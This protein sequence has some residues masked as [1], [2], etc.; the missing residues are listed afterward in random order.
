MAEQVNSLDDILKYL[1]A[2]LSSEEL[3]LE[4]SAREFADKSQEEINRVAQDP[5]FQ[6]K[7]REFSIGR[8]FGSGNLSKGEGAK[9]WDVMNQFIHQKILL[10][11]NPSLDA[12]CKINAIVSQKEGGI[13]R[14]C[15]SFAGDKEFIKPSDLPFFLRAFEESFLKK[16]GANP[17]FEAFMIYTWGTTLHP[18]K[19]GNGRTFR[20]C[21]DWILLGGGLLPVSFSSSV[22]AHVAVSQNTLLPKRSQKFS[23]FLAAHKA[24]YLKL[25]P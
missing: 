11:E 18:F 1:S 8:M 9:E 17:L 2:P 21:S 7:W 25:T 5:S 19:D 13:I 10:G 16:L 24:S 20:G 23:Q 12:I 22:S 14:D 15:Y 3:S 6:N 4:A